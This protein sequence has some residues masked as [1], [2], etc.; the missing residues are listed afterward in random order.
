MAAGPTPETAAS[1]APTARSGPRHSRSERARLIAVAILAVLATLFA[2]L[3]L[4]DVKVHL[5]FGTTELPLIVVIVA[6][7]A[8]GAVFGAV[9]TRRGR[10]GR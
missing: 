3:N 10:H 4:N 6:C 5:L 9:L 7:L 2:V 1:G 8:I